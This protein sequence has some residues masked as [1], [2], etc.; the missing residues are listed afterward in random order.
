V[1]K[2]NTAEVQKENIIFGGTALD[3]P[4]QDAISLL[5]FRGRKFQFQAKTARAHLILAAELSKKRISNLK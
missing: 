5:Y 1:L 4:G 2:N 3:N